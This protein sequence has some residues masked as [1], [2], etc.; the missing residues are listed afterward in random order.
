MRFFLSVSSALPAFDKFD[1]MEALFE[2]V[3]RGLGANSGQGSQ[4]MDL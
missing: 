1:M 4:G 2:H 3:L